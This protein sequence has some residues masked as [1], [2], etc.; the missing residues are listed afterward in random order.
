MQMN[1][2][3]VYSPG[4]TGHLDCL[5]G[6]FMLLECLTDNLWKGFSAGVNCSRSI[7]EK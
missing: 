3:L 1:Y 7:Q 6:W 2:S 5:P 4:T